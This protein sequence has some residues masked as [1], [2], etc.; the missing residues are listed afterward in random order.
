M[1]TF[2]VCP[3]KL[4]EYSVRKITFKLIFVFLLNTQVQ[5]AEDIGEIVVTASRTAMPER[6]VGG[7]V[8]VISRQQIEQRNANTITDVL[9]IA[10]GVAVSQSGGLGSLSQIRLRGAE[11]NQVLILID[12]VEANDPAASS[13]FNFAYL[14]PD[15]IERIEVM[16]G[17][18]SSIWGSDALAGVINIITRPGK[19]K[20]SFSST[21]E[22]GSRNTIQST[23]SAS[24]STQHSKYFLHGLFLDS[25]G[26]NISEQGSEN[27]GYDNISLT[28]NGSY[29]VN[30]IIEAGLNARY[31]DAE[32]EFDNAALGPPIDAE[33]KTKVDQFY[34]RSFLKIATLNDKWMHTISTSLTDTRN[35]ND[36]TFGNTRTEG[37]KLKFDYQSNITFNLPLWSSA[38]HEFTFLLE[39]EVERFRQRG[40]A[41]MF[42]DP[43]QNQDIT[44]I[45]YVGEYRLGA[46]DR[47]FISAAIRKDDNDDFRDR[48]TYRLASAY[49]F[50]QV[51]TKLRAAY[52]TGVKNPSF[53][54]LFGFFPN[55]FV[56]NPGLKPEKSEAWEFGFDQPLF[57]DSA[58]VGATF[59]W[60][61]LKDEI[62]SIFFPINSAINIEGRSERNGVEAYFDAKLFEQISL[63]GSYTYIDS[64]QPDGV[65]KQQREIRRPRNVASL[66]F[67]YDFPSNKGNINIE[68]NYVDEQLDSD[69]SI[70]PAQEVKLDDYTL[71]NVS[72][73]Y[74]INESVN[75]YARVDNLLDDDY[76]DVFGFETLGTAVYAG[77]KVKL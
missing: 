26:I 69:F 39:R 31:T 17:P 3:L 24:G 38:V 35:R 74:N 72:A 34:G 73:S 58:H 50:P 5:A 51:G 7:S 13:E 19:D 20:R 77:L 65:G 46:W 52:G 9:R 6:E 67:N 41:S 32:N 30:D 16:R 76:Q 56:G 2:A 15:S 37:E 28:F 21:V 25:D 27:D 59:F 54:E 66:N 64:T 1:R 49:V 36:D 55:S 33:N 42:G 47:F 44:N 23:L 14:S 63:R 10:P 71:V 75:L 43:N 8:T 29:F 18:Q 62:V 60:E 48:E 40:P 22:A 70:F 57:D 4:W 12:G 61:D 53:T 45:A 11:S 68:V